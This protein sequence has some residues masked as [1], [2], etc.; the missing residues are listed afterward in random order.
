[1]YEIYYVDENGNYGKFAFAFH[2]A[3][4]AIC[5]GR[6]LRDDYN[7]NTDV[8]DNKTGVVIAYFT[9]THNDYIDADV[10]NEFSK[11]TITAM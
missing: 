3:W 8:I 1:M 10:K 9:R 7:Y 4:A 2:S 6:S 5:H 11:R